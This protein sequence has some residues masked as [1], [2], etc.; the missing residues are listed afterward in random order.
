MQQADFEGSFRG[1]GRVSRDHSVSWIP[2]LH[3]FVP[4]EKEDIEALAK[5]QGKTVAQINRSFPI[6]MNSTR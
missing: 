4:T 1:A 6:C 2:P 3:E 5:P